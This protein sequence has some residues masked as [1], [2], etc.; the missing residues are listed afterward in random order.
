[1]KKFLAALLAMTLMLTLVAGAFAETT[2]TMGSWRA[3]DVDQMTALFNLYKEATG[4]QID[5]QPSNPPDYNATLRLQLESGTGPDMMY[6]RSYATGA[7]LFQKGYFADVTDVAGLKDSFTADNLAPW[8]VDG[9]SFAVPLVAVTHAVYYNK[10]IFEANKLEVPTT[11]EEFLKVCETL[12]AAGITPLANGVAEEWDILEC[13][14]LGMLPNYIGGSAE[15]VLYESGE[16]KLND[17][18]F[19][20]AYTDIGKVAPYLPEGFEAV[21]YNDSQV[22]FA[23][24]KAAMFMDGSWTVGTYGEAAFNWGTFAM[25]APE[26]MTTNITYHLDAAIGM[27]AATK[28]PEECKA[29]L[30]WLCTQDG[31]NALAT[32]LPAGMYPVTT[33]PVTLADPHSAEMFNLTLGKTNDVR[34]VW[35]M[36]MDLYSPMNQAVISVLKG[37]ATPQAAADT[38]VAAYDALKK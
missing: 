25:P 26:G 9:K 15:R 7:E 5:F 2:L 21:T 3:D 12:K 13:F 31:V 4:V 16:K 30:A 10:D 35:P 19:V 14:F 18:N 8:T 11:F 20:K 23:T 22:L 33:L 27:N 38:V 29:F 28:Y 36:L 32:Y 6:A 34:F 24:G 37:T 1:M 17:E